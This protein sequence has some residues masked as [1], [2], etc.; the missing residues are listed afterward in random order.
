MH[1]MQVGLVLGQRG[2]E[3]YVGIRPRFFPTHSLVLC[4]GRTQTISSF[5]ILIFGAVVLHPGPLLFDFSVPLSV[6]LLF[7]WSLTL[8]VLNDH[9][10]TQGIKRFNRV[11]LQKKKY[12]PTM[13][14]TISIVL[15]QIS[16]FLELDYPGSI[17]TS[18]FFK[19][20]VLFN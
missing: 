13:A 9:R 5:F 6:S 1:V 12:F 10:Q 4:T 14:C 8:R 7:W 20:C 18:T 3:R 11:H 2:T 15:K 17:Y 16:T 19:T